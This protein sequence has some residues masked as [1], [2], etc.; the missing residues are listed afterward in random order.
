M[1]KHKLNYTYRMIMWTAEE[2]GLVG[3]RQYVK[4]HEAEQRNLQ[5]VMES[6]MGTFMP[7]G[8]DVT[9]TD[10]VK[11]IVE[12]VIQLVCRPNITKTYRDLLIS[13]FL[14]Y[15]VYF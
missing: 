11:C 12:R 8:L 1:H 7:L 4:S 5:F 15:S 6:D 2:V 13:Y 14:I 10:E 9:A 3:A